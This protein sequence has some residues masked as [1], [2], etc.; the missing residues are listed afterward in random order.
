MGNPEE[1]LD[2][3]GIPLKSPYPEKPSVPVLYGVM[4][5]IVGAIGLA[6]AY[7]TSYLTEAKQS[8]ADAKISVLSEYDLGWLYLGVFV[9]KF[10]QLPI[11]ITL[12]AA[13]KASKVNVPDQHVYKVM[14]AEGSKLG[15]V[16]M[17]TEGIHGEFNRAQRALQNYNEQFPSIMMQYLAASWVW[18]FEAFVCIAIFAIAS[19][20]SATG[21]VH[22]AKGRMKGRFFGY[23]A[24][25]TLQGMVLIAAFKALA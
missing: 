12:G 3:K 17:E 11:G 19:C 22:S 6:I 24:V 10:L 9:V 16:L 2:A 8:A 20:L 7:V 4:T 1:E 14:G 15:Y 5:L 18:P 21:Y 13:R 25:A 23:F